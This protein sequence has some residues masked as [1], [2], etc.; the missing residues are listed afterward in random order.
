MK[1]LTLRRADTCVGCGTALAAGTPA[2]W[3]AAART[4]TCLGCGPPDPAPLDR[5]TPGASA[6][7]EGE[8][9]SARREERV[10]ARHPRIGGLVLAVTDDPA[11]TR[12][13]GQGAT[14][15]ERVGAVLEA[16]ADRGVL[17]LHDRRL[18][19]SRANVDHLAVAP[20]G[21]W[22]VDAKRYVGQRVEGRDVGGW[23]RTD[24]RLFVGGRDRTALV[25]GVEGQVA[26][27]RATLDAA[28]HAEVPVHGALCFVEADLRWF[29]KPF[30]LRD[31]L[32]T[33]R[34]ELVAPMLAPP[35][36]DPPTREALLRLL[37]AR[38]RPA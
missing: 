5:G 29:A 32:V 6:R 13:W 28:G 26:A 24:L 16:A 37:A 27:V 38:L 36:V 1:Q 17:V 25:D 21:V 10:R 14:G 30:R 35:V 4:V 23:F 22:V 18:P 31:V 11:S 33:W 34:K 8:R 12:V 3:D 7:R 2:L 9:R 20:S 19:R 15:E